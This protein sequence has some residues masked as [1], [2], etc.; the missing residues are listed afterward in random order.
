MQINWQQFGLRNNPYD[1]LPL[2]EG[3][4]I[5]IE[6]AFVGRSQERQLLKDIFE[7]ENRVCLTIC[8]DTGV[9]KTSL[10]NFHKYMW[11][12][13]T[14]KLLF[15]FRRE[16]EACDD[17]LNKKNFIIE[18]LSSVLREIK[19]LNS[20]LLKNELLTR[21]QSLVDISQA[22][23]ISGG[24]SAGFSGY[25]GGID[26]GRGKSISQPIQFS[27]SALE[28]Y[29]QN[30][31]EFIKNNKIGGNT[32]SGLIIHVNNFDVVLSNKNKSV[33][34]ID[35]F[36]EIR[37]TLQT[38]DT[39]FLF[40]GP[41]NF[42]KDIITAKQRVKSIFYQTPLTLSPLSKS[43][44]V[45]AFDERMKLLKSKGVEDF[46]K[47]IDDEVV[48]LLHDLYDGDIRSIM[49]A[50]RDILGYY[51]EKITNPL[52]VNEAKI[53]LGRE[54]MAKIEI[55]GKLTKGQKNILKFLVESGRQMSL[56]EASKLLKRPVPNI[57][58]HYFKPLREMGIIEKKEKTG[59]SI[60][61]GLTKDY[62]PLKWFYES[63]KE[64][65]KV[66]ENATN[67]ESTLF[68]SMI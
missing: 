58:Q 53:L 8:G 54:R 38:K 66:I 15:S 48:Y 51:S 21:I 67:K 35:F 16:I 29:F 60:L 55:A 19:L 31:V 5:A 2:I 37:D 39:F 44:V 50:I 43:E 26:F 27:T 14:Q 13:R 64:V 47:P 33:S 40:L 56:S 68:D 57:S 32:Y 30:I 61:W 63:Q 10:A 18:I 20:D 41:R 24:V 23:N 34:V 42:F 9:G 4:D 25:S 6:D 7:S 62:E 46:V 36:N 52:S 65:I 28:K 59:R 1:T 12:Y 45:E 3:G 49:S 17:L 11:K 22:M